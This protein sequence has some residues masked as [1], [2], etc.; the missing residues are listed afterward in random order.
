MGYNTPKFLGGARIKAETLN[1]D[2]QRLVLPERFAGRRCLRV[3][4]A[5]CTAIR[6]RLCMPGFLCCS[7]LRSWLRGTLSKKSA[8]DVDIRWCC[9]RF[10]T[11]KCAKKGMVFAW[12]ITLQLCRTCI[13]R[14][15]AWLISDPVP[16]YC[17]LQVKK[18]WSRAVIVTLF[19]D[20]HFV[21][22]RAVF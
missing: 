16:L 8:P 11:S 5:E 22:L 6:R 4:V 20:M 9:C 21:K 7:N 17:F 12:C 13:S 3:K 18:G 15:G 14:E 2:A 1:L 10:S 19:S